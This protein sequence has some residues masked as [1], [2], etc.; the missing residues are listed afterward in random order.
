MDPSWTFHIRFRI[1]CQLNKVE[2]D[3]LEVKQDAM[4]WVMV[5]LPFPL[6]PHLVASRASAPAW[7]PANCAAGLMSGVF[8]GSHTKTD[9]RAPVPGLYP[10][11]VWRSCTICR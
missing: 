11:V 5:L 1:L 7:Y 10:A 2:R 8:P 6:P 4:L 9:T 3:E